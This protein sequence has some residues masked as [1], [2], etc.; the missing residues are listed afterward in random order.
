MKS[1]AEH[2][3]YVMESFE[4]ESGQILKNVNV[5]YIISGR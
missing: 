4:F 2:G 1:N 3:I 5:E